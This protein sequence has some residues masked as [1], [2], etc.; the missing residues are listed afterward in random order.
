[1]YIELE[2]SWWWSRQKGREEGV[3]TKDIVGV[4]TYI[5]TYLQSRGRIKT[6]QRRYKEPTQS[7]TSGQE[8]LKN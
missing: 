4:F 6:Q 1:M 3:K 2:G 7:M 8:E 5:H